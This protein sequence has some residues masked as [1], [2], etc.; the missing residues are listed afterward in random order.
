MRTIVVAIHQG[1]CPE[2]FVV[3]T[4]IDGTPRS[5]R[6]RVVLP[7]MFSVTTEEAE[8]Y[9][10]FELSMAPRRIAR[11]VIAVYKREPVVLPVDLGEI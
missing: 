5:F 9:D 7:G 11:L 10:A 1:S 3:D 4:L 6:L 2:E 8:F